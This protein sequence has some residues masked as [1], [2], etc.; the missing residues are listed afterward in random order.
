MATQPITIARIYL[1]EG[2]HLLGKLMDFL[3]HE[4]KVAGLTVLRGIAGF[5]TDGRVHTASLADLSLDLPLVLEFYDTPE[6]VVAVLDRLESLMNV[7]H[8]IS[9]PACLHVPGA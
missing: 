3:H 5:G 8:L 2:E 4:E 7:P 9:W 6:R 1:R